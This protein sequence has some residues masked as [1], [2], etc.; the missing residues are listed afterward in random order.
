DVVTR[1]ASGASD[2]SQVDGGLFTEVTGALGP[3]QVSTWS[4][5]VS[6]ALGTGELKAELA[7][8]SGTLLPRLTLAGPTG[9][10]LIQSDSGEIV[11][12]LQPGTYLLSVSDQTG[13]GT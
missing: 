8:E 12:S 10:T 4:F 3:G 13:G 5:T 7:T 2:L 9:Q 11:Q 1:A 6:D